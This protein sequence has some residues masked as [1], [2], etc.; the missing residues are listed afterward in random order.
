L[1]LAPLDVCLRHWSDHLPASIPEIPAKL[2]TST[3]C[4]STT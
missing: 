3:F 1:D 2:I 4:I